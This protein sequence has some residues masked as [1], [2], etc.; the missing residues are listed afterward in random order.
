MAH[1]VQFTLQLGL[2]SLNKS[3]VFYCHYS[4]LYK[5]FQTSKWNLHI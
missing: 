5:V 4:T 3:K 2:E 1:R